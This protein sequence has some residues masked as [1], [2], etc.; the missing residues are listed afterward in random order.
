MH[1][2]FFR[3]MDDTQAWLRYGFQTSNTATLAVSGT[4]HAAMEMAVAN[5]VEPGDKVIVG[6]NGER[7]DT[8]IWAAHP[9]EA[10]IPAS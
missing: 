6:V 7:Q 3:I 5:T 4:G 2:E 10:A 8:H 9:Y 1:P